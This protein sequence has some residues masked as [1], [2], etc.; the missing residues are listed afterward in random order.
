MSL[1]AMQQPTRPVTVIRR[2]DPFR[3]MEDVYSRMS[4]LME[5]F[6]GQLPATLA[7]IEETDA[8]YIVEMDLPGVRTEDVSLDLRDN[9]LRISGEIKEKERKG[10]LRRRSRRVGEFE[11]VVTLP[12]EVNPDKVEA[13]LSDGVLTVR[14]GKASTSKQRHIEIKNK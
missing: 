12:G 13:K 11:H 14:L 3:D 8:A 5:G 2:W 4:Q 1:T 9:E 10:V 7:D 6:A